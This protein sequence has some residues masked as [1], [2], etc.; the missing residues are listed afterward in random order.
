MSTKNNSESQA[1]EH[2]GVAVDIPTSPGANGATSTTAGPRAPLN[3]RATEDASCFRKT[4]SAISRFAPKLTLIKEITHY[5]S[6]GD[7]KEKLGGDVS[8][9]IVVA[10]MLIPQGMAYAQLAGMPPVY[11]L[12]TS[13]SSLIVYSLFAT[14]PQ[15]AVGPVAIASLLTSAAVSELFPETENDPGRYFQVVF[16]LTFMVGLLQ[17]IMGLFRVGYVVNFLS[18]PVLRGFTFAA[19]LI[20]GFSQF[21]K[22]LGFKVERSPY[23]Y[24]VIYRLLANIESTKWRVVLLAIENLTLLVSLKYLKAVLGETSMCQ[25]AA[26]RAKRN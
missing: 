16:T 4:G 7:W 8:A 19:A 2:G 11:G 17:L 22:L 1:I 21:D 3:V 26:V 20:I 24:I 25:E 9:G 14:S 12:Y 5:N 23:V 6:S 15:L 18:H 10:V 13:I